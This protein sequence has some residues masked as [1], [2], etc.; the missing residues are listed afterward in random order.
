MAFRPI[1]VNNGPEFARQMLV[2]WAYKASVQ[3][4]FIRPGNPN[5]NAYI[6]SFN[7]NFLD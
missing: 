5:E 1:T 2:R 7:G 4:T 6:E 3:V